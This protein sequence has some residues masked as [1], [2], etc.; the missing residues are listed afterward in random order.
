M[1]LTITHL[2]GS[3]PVQGDGTVE[4]IPFYFRARGQHWSMAI[5]ADPVAI[6]C[7]YK[8]GWYRQEKWGSGAFD[9]GFM[10]KDEA[11]GLIN[12]CAEEYARSMVLT[13]KR[14]ANKMKMSKEAADMFGKEIC[15]AK[16]RGTP[17]FAKVVG[18]PSMFFGATLKEAE[19]KAAKRARA[20]ARSAGC[21]DM[22]PLIKSGEIG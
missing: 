1:E 6:S 8:S 7:G 19:K 17:Y 3:C 9:A 13:G 16:A 15:R 14:K 10:K 22:P 18:S 12:R 11:L 5:G 2:G 4:G 21:P 20:M